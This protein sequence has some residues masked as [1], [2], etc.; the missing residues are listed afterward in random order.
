[1]AHDL[2]DWVKMEVVTERPG[3]QKFAWLDEQLELLVKGQYLRFDL[4]DASKIKTVRYRIGDVSKVLNKR[5]L[6]KVDGLSLWVW[7]NDRVTE[8]QS[9]TRGKDIVLPGSNPPK[10]KGGRPRKEKKPE[11]CTVCGIVSKYVRSDGLCTD[12]W[13]QQ[14]ADMARR[15]QQEA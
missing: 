3:G 11:R 9:I 1:M 5:F 2:P 7:V 10:N 14:M 4:A 12:C 13:E 15:V 8:P 6:T